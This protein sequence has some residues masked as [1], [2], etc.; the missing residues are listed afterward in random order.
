MNHIVQ[1]V[2]PLCGAV[3][4]VVV[5]DEGLQAFNFYGASVQDAFPELS[6]EERETLL[7]GFCAGCQEGIFSGE[8][9]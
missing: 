4:T 9:E 8:E 7:T 5:S 3:T 6:P 1:K 2:C